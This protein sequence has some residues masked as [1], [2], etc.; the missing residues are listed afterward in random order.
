L[1]QGAVSQLT[2]LSRT[3]AVAILDAA[4]KQMLHVCALLHDNVNNLPFTSIIMRI[5]SHS[6][7]ACFFCWP[8]QPELHAAFLL[9][10]AFARCVLVLVVPAAGWC[11]AVLVHIRPDERRSGARTSKRPIKSSS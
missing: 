10:A 9:L 3:T 2:L 7:P 8:H 4:L 5:T 11:L 6:P 1:L